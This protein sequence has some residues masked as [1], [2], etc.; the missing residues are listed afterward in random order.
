M[1]DK[2]LQQTIKLI[3]EDKLI[4]SLWFAT[5]GGVFCGDII[6]DPNRI[7]EKVFK[8]QPSAETEQELPK[9]PVAS[10]K[11]EPLLFIENAKMIVQGTTVSINTAI[12]HE[13]TIAAWGFGEFN[14]S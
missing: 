3:A 13:S 8:L 2:L 12:I 1:M 11:S 9:V 5:S 7:A 10:G 14:L 4:T 6:T